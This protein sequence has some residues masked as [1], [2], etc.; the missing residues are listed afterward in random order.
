MADPRSVALEV[1]WAVEDDDAYANLLLP[2]RIAAAGLDERDAGLATELTYGTLRRPPGCGLAVGVRCGE[3]ATHHGTV[4][5]PAVP[6]T[7]E[8]D[9]DLFGH[10]PTLRRSPFSGVAG[11]RRAYC[12]W[13]PQNS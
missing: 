10:P 6:T 13:T 7:N 11:G 5:E 8:G 2:A 3:V 4:S 1:L 9:R 12:T